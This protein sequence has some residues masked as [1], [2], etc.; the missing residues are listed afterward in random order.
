MTPKTMEPRI[1][2]KIKLN[3]DLKE[4]ERSVAGIVS[5]MKEPALAANVMSM[6][7]FV[8]FAKS[9]TTSSTVCG[10]V[11]DK[12]YEKRIWPQTKKRKKKFIEN[13]EA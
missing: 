3:V 13:I 12:I 9:E 4:S 11:L 6:L 10:P 2:L 7:C 1:M 8:S 5:A